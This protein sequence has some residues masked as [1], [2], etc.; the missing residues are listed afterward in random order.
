MSQAEIEKQN[1]E[2]SRVIILSIASN[3]SLVIIKLVIG[4]MTG[5]VSIIAEALHSGNDL[6]ASL[7]AYIGV[8]KSLKPPDED[9]QYGH[10]KVETI[11]GWIENILI[12]II[13][14]T[15]VYK[16]AM[17]YLHRTPYQMVEIGIAVMVLSGLVNLLVSVYLIKKG[18]ELRSVGVEI[19][20]EH[21][22]A[23]VITSLG[24]ALALGLLK[25]TGLWWIDPLAAVLIGFWVMGIF[26]ALS[27]KLTQQMLDRGLSGEEIG[28]IT[29]TLCAFSEVKGYHR[30][31]TRQSGSTVFI[32]MHV[33]VNKSLSVEKAHTLTKEIENALMQKFVNSSILIHIEPFEKNNSL[34]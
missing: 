32:D 21:L 13:G 9:H 31:R 6:L 30:L 7:I 3:L 17:K 5:L 28:I 26:V 19:D 8:N 4:F 24:T 12:L 2:K 10:G 29:E 11:T 25:L 1:R 22:R 14:I 18:R 20:G 33:K 15:I 27:V 34:Q 16:G 23:D